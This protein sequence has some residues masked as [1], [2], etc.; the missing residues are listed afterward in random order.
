MSEPKDPQTPDDG[1]L[2]RFLR[3][4]EVEAL[5][6]LARSTIYQMISDGE[7]PSSYRLSQRAVGW[8]QRDIARW[9]ESRQPTKRH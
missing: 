1:E 8:K 3:L 7:F 4:A 9:I 5:I 6:G 2:D